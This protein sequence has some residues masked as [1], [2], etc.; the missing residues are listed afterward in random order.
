MTAHMQKRLTMIIL[1]LSALVLFTATDGSASP[2]FE[3]TD[4]V[5]G[6]EG[7]T[8]SFDIGDV[9]GTFEANL[10]D[11]SFGPL[12]FEYLGLSISTATQALGAI[13]SPGSFYFNGIPGTTYYANIFAVGAGKHDTGLFGVQVASVPI[14]A[15]LVMFLS[16]I[17]LI[18]VV[19]RRSPASG[20]RI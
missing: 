20:S 9:P 12:A 13:E 3:V 19:R 11:L 18:S 2:V 8:F 14:P 6:I 4:Y 16:G 15:S 5:T 7:L 1:C 17:I 10:N